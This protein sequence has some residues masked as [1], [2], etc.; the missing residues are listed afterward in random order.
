MKTYKVFLSA[1]DFV[2]VVAKDK[3]AA[4][5][6]AFDTVANAPVAWTVVDVEEGPEYAVID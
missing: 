5:E 4:I 3:E 2:E 6:N 1:N